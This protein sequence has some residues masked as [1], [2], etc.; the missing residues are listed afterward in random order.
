MFRR[1]S[2][3]TTRGRTIALGT[4]RRIRVSISYNALIAWNLF[5]TSFREFQTK[6]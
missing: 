2:A 6:E 4:T 1:A 3:L 5:G